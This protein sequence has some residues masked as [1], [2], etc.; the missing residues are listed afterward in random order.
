MAPG[1][2][3]NLMPF[4]VHALDNSRIAG[5]WVV[6]LTLT[7]IIADDEESSFNVVGFEDVLKWRHGR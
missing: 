7:P 6:N 5:L 2:T 3:A 1:M 4:G